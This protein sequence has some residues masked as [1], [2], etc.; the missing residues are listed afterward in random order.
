MFLLI[1][2]IMIAI[3]QFEHIVIAIQKLVELALTFKY[4]SLHYFG[5]IV[6]AI[7]KPYSSSTISLDIL[8]I[9][10]AVWDGGCHYR[11]SGVGILASGCQ[12]WG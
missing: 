2:V 1:H 10:M 4:H 11:R 7:K 8:P 5:H 12:G 3:H 6:I 9:C